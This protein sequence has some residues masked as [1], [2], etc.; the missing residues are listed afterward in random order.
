MLYIYILIYITNTGLD[1]WTCSEKMKDIFKC[2]LYSFT[3]S[4][5]T[6]PLSFVFLF[7]LTDCVEGLLYSFFIFAVLSF[8]FL[9]SVGA[10]LKL[11]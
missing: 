10:C 7:F 6:E 3:Q 1:V 8:A 11:P 2:C 4:S 5:I 9:Y